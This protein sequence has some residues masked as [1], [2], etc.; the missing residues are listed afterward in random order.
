MTLPT[1][2]KQWREASGLTQAQAA[3]RLRVSVRTYR[4]WEQGVRMPSAF[5][6]Q[7]LL[8]QIG[9]KEK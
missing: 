5:A 1:Q 3:A 2:L 7:A 8:K 4:N 9:V 6:L